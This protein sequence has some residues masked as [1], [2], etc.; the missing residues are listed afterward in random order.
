MC[1]RPPQLQHKYM[2]RRVVAV[3]VVLVVAVVAGAAA[4]ACQPV[5]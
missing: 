2:T 5:S 3:I 4:V 1:S